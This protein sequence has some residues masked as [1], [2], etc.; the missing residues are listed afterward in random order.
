MVTEWRVVH[1]CQAV[2]DGWMEGRKGG[3]CEEGEDGCEEGEDGWMEG[4]RWE[5]KCMV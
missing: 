3:G 5:K 2:G 1:P 4:E